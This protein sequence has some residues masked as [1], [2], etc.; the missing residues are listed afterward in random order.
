[1]EESDFSFSL[2]KWLNSCVKILKSDE[3]MS[4]FAINGIAGFILIGISILIGYFLFPSLDYLLP[5]GSILIIIGVVTI[6]QL[7]IANK[8]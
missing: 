8:L 2:W 5:I 7:R 1:M 4:T 6:L 3:C